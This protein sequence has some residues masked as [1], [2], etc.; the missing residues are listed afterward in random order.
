MSIKNV[1]E[2]IKKGNLKKVYL[3]YGEEEFLMDYSLK[4]IKDK[5]ID[6][7]L[8]SLNYIVFEGKDTPLDSIYNAC[9][10]LP[11]M[12]QKRIVVVKDFGCFSRKKKDDG[13]SGRLNEDEKKLASY[14]LT[15]ED[16][17]CL[18]FME[19][20]VKVDRSKKIVKKV[21]EVGEI[22][23]YTKLKGIELNSWIG[24]TFK[25]YGKIISKVNINY[26]VQYS[27]YFDSNG[28]KTLY[29][30]EN[31]IIKIC[32]YL[33]EKIEVQ[34]EDIDKVMTKSLE[35]NIFKLLDSIAQKDVNNSLRILNEMII[36]NEPTQLILYMIIRQ[37]RLILVSKLLK[38]KG[39][40]NKSSIEKLKI[41][42]YE[43]KKI[44]NQSFNFTIPKMEEALNHCL[45]TDKNVKNGIVD[46][47][48][49]L[50]MLL[51][52]LCN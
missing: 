51:I 48:L 33:G 45:E 31:E 38:E 11:F 24:K 46:S 47:K 44:S 52:S 13:E 34:K 37:L 12:S 39:Y 29:D 36:S 25:K 30:L 5:Y 6:S 3:F 32:N 1:M 14:F 28:N 21:K 7:G 9:E 50:E 20:G 4:V 35:T 10:T 42:E 41:S 18:I 43:F 23:E 40:D 17:L 19:K 49:A 26:F 8:E 2:D 27:S 16:Y 22:V 15:L